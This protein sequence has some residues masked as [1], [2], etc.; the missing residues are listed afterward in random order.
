[1]SQTPPPAD[2]SR[3]D[4][5]DPS[6]QRDRGDDRRAS[7]D[8][9][10]VRRD[11]ALGVSRLVM[12]LECPRCGGRIRLLAAIQPPDVTQAILECLEL[13]SRASPTAPAFS[14]PDD[15]ELQAGDFQATL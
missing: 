2:A 15:A 8:L 4:E 1:L 3:R 12:G 10:T 9:D 5:A 7:P 13:P 14:D 11:E 6:R